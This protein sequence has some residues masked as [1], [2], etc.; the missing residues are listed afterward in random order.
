MYGSIFGIP[1]QMDNSSPLSKKKLK[2]VN[3]FLNLAFLG[4][5]IL[6]LASIVSFYYYKTGIGITFSVISLG[7]GFGSF[8]SSLKLFKSR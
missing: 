8:L 4:I 3:I 6:A 5:P 2:I 7:L 1:G